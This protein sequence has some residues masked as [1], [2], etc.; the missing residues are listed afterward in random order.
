MYAMKY[1]IHSYSIWEQG[2][3]PRQEDSIYPE[4]GRLCDDDR[5]FILC[6]GMGGHSA[7][8]VASSTVCAAMS[9]Y[10]LEKYQDPQGPF[11]DDDFAAALRSAFDALDEVD[12]GDEK[13]MGTTLAFLKLHSEGC[14]IAHM[15]DSRV[16]HIRAGKDKDTTEILFQTTDHS[17]VNDL[18][19][20][21]EMTPEEA[22]HSK[23]KN[24]ITRAM[25]PHMERRPRADI[26]HTQDIKPGDYFMLCSDGILE[27]ME[28]DN[29][30]YIFSEKGG[31]DEHKVDVLKKVTENN[32]DN[33]SAIIVHILDVEG[34]SEQLSGESFTEPSENISGRLSE[35]NSE[36][37]PE[38]FVPEL[39]VTED[40][41]ED[42]SPKS[43]PRYFRILRWAI[44]CAIVVMLVV[45]GKSMLQRHAEGESAVE[46][47]P[48]PNE[49]EAVREPARPVRDVELSEQED[50]DAVIPDEALNT[51]PEVVAEDSSLSS[52][53][54]AVDDS[55]SMEDALPLPDADDGQDGAEE[56]ATAVVDDEDDED[57]EDVPASDE[58]LAREILNKKDHQE[59]ETDTL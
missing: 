42:D 23:R 2:P 36:K 27:Q 51:Q 44:I 43:M 7:G 22:R 21:G 14:T 38:E 26:Y 13:K 35:D 4:Q 8:D 19:K 57:D 12:N 17:L 59:E 20:I 33:H 10:I 53:E 49:V 9:R 3:R 30:K 45:V 56:E 24:V 29:L 37:S 40:A 52:S 39:P 31:D 1:I 34:V 32:R 25:Q 41:L 50:P 55:V 47:E 18:V 5:L 48:A 11:S 16:Y 28:D 46:P 6:D 54:Q 15:G 58:Q